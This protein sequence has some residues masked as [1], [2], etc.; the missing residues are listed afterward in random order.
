MA[1]TI[2]IVSC[3]DGINSVEDFKQDCTQDFLD[4]DSV[5][6]ADFIE[7]LFNFSEAF[8]E[9]EG[10]ELFTYDD[11]TR[12]LVGEDNQE[13]DAYFETFK[14]ESARYSTQGFDN[15]ILN[16]ESFS[17]DLASKF[18]EFRTSAE[19]FILNTHP[20]LQEYQIFISNY[21]N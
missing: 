3:E 11:F 17:E 20:T 13:A 5:G 12:A 15:Y 1:F 8:Y 6:N 4:A 7:K 9:V 21:T 18:I 2:F 10:A 16:T 14:V 19:D